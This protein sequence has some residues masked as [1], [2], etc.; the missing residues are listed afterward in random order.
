MSGSRYDVVGIGNAIVDVLAQV[1]DGFLTQHGLTRGAMALIDDKQA[2]AL[3][4]ALPPGIECSG[5]SA[6]NTIAGVAML[7]GRAAF[8]GKVRGDQLG[9]VFT[10]DIRAVGV[11][12]DTPFATTGLPTARCLIAVTPD[13]QRTMNT[14][15]GASIALGPDDVDEKLIAESA[16]TYL[17]GYLWDPPQAK[18]A[19]RRAMTIAHKAGR[20]VALSLSDSFCVG[21]YRA[22]FRHLVEHEV[23]I[24]FANEGE[25]TSLYETDSF[26]AA[27]AQVRKL[28]RIA[29]LTRS[30]KGSVMVQGDTVHTIAATPQGPVVDTTGAGDLYAAGVLAGL[31]QGRDLATA[32]RMGSLCAGAV[33]AQVG[34]RPAKDLKALVARDGKA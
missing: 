21:R 30:E 7:G 2:E 13:A 19:F 27:L 34:A 16:V 12:F 23:D 22:E 15:L 32:G 18:E 8:I 24:L 4:A 26:D 31:T 29:A 11:A 25:I 14:F 20:K 6:A 10:H 28:G 3:Y 1:Q 9:Q 33:I 17:E 5:G